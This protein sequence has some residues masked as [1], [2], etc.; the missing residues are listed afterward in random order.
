MPR[1]LLVGLAALAVA[2]P[3]AG[4]PAKAAWGVKAWAGDPSEAPQLPLSSPSDD[5]G[6]DIKLPPGY[7]VAKPTDTEDAGT[8]AN[9]VPVQGYTAPGGTG[10]SFGSSLAGAFTCETSTTSC[11]MAVA[12]AAGAA[13]YCTD[14]A[15][16]RSWGKA[17]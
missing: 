1:L 14:A 4:R 11:A 10:F 6:P 15:G 17:H 9:A 5:G 7:G 8:G 3:L 16:S 2:G 13:C 12:R